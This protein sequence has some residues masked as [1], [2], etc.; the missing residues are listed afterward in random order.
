MLEEAGSERR[1]EGGQ[2]GE[3][4]EEVEAAVSGPRDHGIL[5]TG[6]HASFCEI[7]RQF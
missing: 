6:N 2:W 5:Q 1:E 3:A 7:F 4:G